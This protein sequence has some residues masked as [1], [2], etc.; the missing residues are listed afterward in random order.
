MNLFAGISLTETKNLVD[1][2]GSFH[3]STERYSLRELIF[4]VTA[5]KSNHILFRLSWRRRYVE[6]HINVAL[7]FETSLSG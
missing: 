1:V 3:F 4:L 6:H 2:D 5:S 7:Y